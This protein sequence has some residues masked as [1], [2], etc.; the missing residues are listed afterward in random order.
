MLLGMQ[1]RQRVCISSNSR[2]LR[3]PIH[4]YP[5]AAAPFLARM[6]PVVPY[7]KVSHLHR[8]HT[9]PAVN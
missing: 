8:L 9:T 5:V 6:H 7:V 1:K 4:A 3:S 2:V